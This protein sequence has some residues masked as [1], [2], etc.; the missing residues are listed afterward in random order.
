MGRKSLERMGFWTSCL[1]AG[2]RSGVYVHVSILKNNVSPVCGN[3]FAFYSNIAAETLYPDDDTSCACGAW[4]CKYQIS[5]RAHS[6]AGGLGT[7][8]DGSSFPCHGCLSPCVLFW[9]PRTHG[10]IFKNASVSKTQ[11]KCFSTM[12][13]PTPCLLQ[14][15]PDAA[16]VTEAKGSAPE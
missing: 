14:S 8:V 2:E 10:S 16:G 1:L 6:A 7:C 5:F 4:S 11:G 9:S 12:H 3:L 15:L 13:W